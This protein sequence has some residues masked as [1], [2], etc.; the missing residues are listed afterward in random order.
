MYKPYL[1]SVTS[2]LLLWLLPR[3]LVAQFGF[4]DDETIARLK[5]DMAV[6]TA[7]SLKGRLAGTPF[8]IKARNYL[9]NV[10]REAGLKPAFSDSSYIQTFYAL[11]MKRQAFNVG[12]FI[13]NNAQ[14]TIIV[15]AHYDHIG[16]GYSS[17]RGEPGNI[18]YGADDN[19]SGVAVMCELARRLNSRNDLKYNWLFIAFSAEEAGLLGS[20]YFVDSPDMKKYNPAFMI[21]F[22][23]VGRFNY[24]GRNK[25]ITYGTGTSKSWKPFLRSV[26]KPPFKLK[27]MP[28]GPPFSDHA[29]FYEDSIP[30]L[31]FTTGL[32]EE[33]HTQHDTYATINFE[34]MCQITNW[35]YGLLSQA[36]LQDPPQYRKCNSW[37]M[38]RAYVFAFMM[39]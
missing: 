4:T 24:D 30:I 38:F 25:L 18:H 13:N 23:M 26:E 8:E 12:G 20:K 31:Y 3:L 22:D 19:A 33:Y 37:Q 28:F 2:L 17:S 34:G 16:M 10:L 14:Q 15:G 27:K 35:V 21:N 9:V 39:M 11:E 32:P 1:R 6:L 36:A 5:S 29:P 7:D